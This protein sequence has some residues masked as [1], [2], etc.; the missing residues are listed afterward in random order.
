MG[1]KRF[2]KGEHHRVLW[3]VS[4]SLAETRPEDHDAAISNALAEVGSLTKFG[5]LGTYE[6][7]LARGTSR[8]T[9]IWHAANAPEALQTAETRAMDTSIAAQ[10]FDGGGIAVVPALELESEP[11][12]GW[13]DGTVIIALID[14]VGDRVWTLVGAVPRSEFTDNELALVRD[15]ATIVR[16]YYARIRVEQDL[17]RRLDLEGFVVRSVADLGAVSTATLEAVVSDV[18][19]RVR[20]RFDL[21]SVSVFRV[22]DETLRLKFHVGESPVSLF[23]EYERA[24]GRALA[25]SNTEIMSLPLLRVAEA[26]LGPD[27]QY[28]A[29]DDET[30]I[31][32]IPTDIGRGN[33][34]NL[35]LVHGSRTWDDADLDAVRLI[36]PAI[37]HNCARVEAEDLLA[38]REGVQAELAAV[39]ADFLRL[40]RASAH[41]GIRNGFQRVCMRLG[42][43]LGVVLER[44]GEEEGIP[45]VKSVWADGL[46][47]LSE[48]E[49]LTVLPPQLLEPLFE[50]N[51]PVSAVMSTA[52]LVPEMRDLLC[53]S[54]TW[55][56]VAA[57]IASSASTAAVV[58]GLAGDHSDRLETIVELFTTFGDLLSQV[59]LRLTAEAALEREAEAQALLRRSATALLN[60]DGFEDAV[61]DVLRNVVDFLD[62]SALT[63]WQVDAKSHSYVVRYSVGRCCGDEVGSRVDVGAYP[64]VDT[65]VL[66]PGVPSAAG[67]TSESDGSRS[68]AIARGTARLE[69]VLIASRGEG[70]LDDLCVR[71]L[72]Q[73]SGVLGRMEE[74]VATERYSQNS[75]LGA[76]VGIVLCDSDW[77]ISAANP[78]FASLA[79]HEQPASLGGIDFPLLFQY[80][81][82]EFPTGRTECLMANRKGGEVWVRTQVT[83]VPAG[84]NPLFLVHVED[85]TAQHR[86]DQLLRFQATHDEL[87][88]LANRRI[89]LE[90]IDEQLASGR[91]P[92]VLLL[93][94]DRFKNINDTLGHGRGDELLIITADRLRSALRPRDL[95]VRLGGDE[96]AVLLRSPK[97]DGDAVAV[98]ERL[99]AVV[100]EPVSLG[101]QTVFPTASIGI[102]TADLSMTFEQILRYADMAMYR[103]KADGRARYKIFDNVMQ[104]QVA[105]RLET[106]TG[107]RHAIRNGE[108]E[109]HYQPEVSLLDGSI[110]GAEALVRWRHPERGLVPAASF[111]PVAE[112]TGMIVEI[113]DFV[114]YEA[115]RQAA[116]WPKPDAII[117]VN[118]SA[119]Q[120]QRS[121]TVEIVQTALDESG[122]APSRLCVEI[123]ESAMMSDVALAEEVLGQLR[124]LGVAIAVD[125]FGT[126]FSSLAYLK[127]FPVSAVKLDRT[128]VDGLD[129]EANDDGFV[130]SIISLADALGL[131]VVAEG[132]ENQAQA[133]ALVRLGCLKAQGYFF[134]R[135]APERELSDRM[136]A[137]CRDS[138]VPERSV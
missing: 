99:L 100:S 13:E 97:S 80:D 62:L 18:L 93:D 8:Q 109:V 76:P 121:E 16:Q 82:D 138:G 11:E 65:A 2:P 73:L 25:I 115:C 52:E 79:G 111:V 78:A 67:E 131:D 122:L 44:G 35:V 20:D 37:A 14:M 135:P 75:F 60:V 28:V 90:A 15:F 125:D 136:V 105:K 66:N 54:E 33:R 72:D 84:G 31:T 98:A 101:G 22:D 59:R 47:S 45:W 61:N 63:S 124:E 9:H 46:S 21:Q 1:R 10:V 58:I 71:T 83:T 104:E 29:P 30:F 77:T 137:E 119:A 112:D 110:I 132:V 126:G 24:E 117:R 127:R 113:G 123:T 107:L 3:R 120:L 95:A 23:D 57:P 70:H 89:L 32:Y 108:L 87:T 55:T 74:H 53:G 116:C 4:D 94:L 6:T 103:A 7:D 81:G 51:E 49:S 64:F 50:N 41:D 85:I 102:V 34:D 5:G 106:E 12:P 96:F 43:P 118:F 130:R 92:R 39:A 42:S 36:A 134:G 69:S 48:D 129:D 26:I 56:A 19:E 133:D 40:D 68:L 114:L 27:Q 38:Y 86:S 91:S 17:Q 128:F 88:G